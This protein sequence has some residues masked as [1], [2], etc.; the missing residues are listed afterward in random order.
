[1]IVK[2]HI[3]FDPAA[4]INGGAAPLP[5]SL[6]PTDSVGSAGGSGGSPRS[7]SDIIDDGV[8]LGA[9]FPG[10]E[11]TENVIEVEGEAEGVEKAE[12]PVS[13]EKAGQLEKPTDGTVLA[14]EDK[15]EGFLDADA[16]KD[17]SKVTPPAKKP[18]EK[19]AEV[20]ETLSEYSKLFEEI[21]AKKMSKDAV[22]FV[23][24]RIRQ[25]ESSDK[26]TKVLQEQLKNKDQE[27]SKFKESTKSDRL[28]ESYYEHPEAFKLTKDFQDLSTQ[29]SDIHTAYNHYEQQ[30]MKIEANEKWNQ[31][32]RDPRTGRLMLD[33]TPM[34]PVPGAR[35][36][37][38][39]HLSRLQG[40][41]TEN[42]KSQKTLEASYAQARQG[43]T[44]FVDKINNKF[45][46]EYDGF[47]GSDT[48]HADYNEYKKLADN[49]PPS[50]K[51][52]P[53]FPTLA[54]AYLRIG[55]LYQKLSELQKAKARE[56]VDNKVSKQSVKK[57][58]TKDSSGKM[59]TAG[60]AKDLLFSDDVS[61]QFEQLMK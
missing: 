61:K 7:G 58:D 17:D 45:F 53:L 29:E 49:V 50:V 30:L 40:Q 2:R 33:P 59:A 43:I 46:P 31:L 42:I 37:L 10:Q 1:M 36:Q 26:T 19:A 47:D 54:R 3:Q 55:H 20:E 28:P 15:P 34:E 13:T 41:Y 21:F 32:V 56:T 16:L 6:K 57:S 39:T 35:A 44:S 38:L 25:L 18:E 12:K 8:D 60:D 5:Q 51:A 9:G 11:F 24:A 4:P 52:M 27:F 22:D 23:R 14:K 48:K